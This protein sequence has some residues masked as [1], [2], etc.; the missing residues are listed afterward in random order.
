[1]QSLTTP[2]PVPF[3]HWPLRQ[4]SQPSLSEVFPKVKLAVMMPPWFPM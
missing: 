3:C 2:A 4:F 1:M